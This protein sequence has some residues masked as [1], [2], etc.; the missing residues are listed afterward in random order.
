VA[1][2]AIATLAHAACTSHAEQELCM[3]A[4]EVV[5]GTTHDCFWYPH[6]GDGAQCQRFAA[7]SQDCVLTH[8]SAADCEAIPGCHWD[9][10]CHGYP[11]AAGESCAGSEGDQDAM[12]ANTDAVACYCSRD[13]AADEQC[14]DAPTPAPTTTVTDAGNQ[15]NSTGNNTMPNAAGGCVHINN[16]PEYIDA[17]DTATTLN[18]CEVL[19]WGA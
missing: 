19:C 16:V 15:L 17:P 9:E 6:R 10:T 12:Y 5:A 18:L 3:A 14:V 8:T 13:A 1:L 11:T 4:D 2:A 7:V